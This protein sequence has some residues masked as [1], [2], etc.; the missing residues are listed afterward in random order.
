[1]IAQ[2]IDRRQTRDRRPGGKQRNHADAVR[3]CIDII[4]KVDQQRAADRPP[5]QILGDRRMQ[6]AQQLKTA[7]DITD[8]INTPARPQ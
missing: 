7:M 6:R 5:R 8:R 4:P 3:S 1:M 2:K